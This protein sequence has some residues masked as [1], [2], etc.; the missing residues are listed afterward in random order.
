M[1]KSAFVL[2]FV[3]ILFLLAACG[4]SPEE[5]A[6]MTAAAATDTPTPTSTP[7]NTPTPT[8]TPTPTPIPYDLTVAVTD[9]EDGSPITTGQVSVAESGDGEPTPL[10]DAGNAVWLGLPG[11]TASISVTAQGYVGAEQST[12]LERGPNVVEI[13]LERDPRQVLPATACMEGETVAYIEDFEDGFAQGWDWANQG[14]PEGWLVEAGPNETLM[15][16]AAGGPHD[17]T[18]YLILDGNFRLDFDF[19]RVNGGAATAIGG[20]FT[21]YSN[22]HISATRI[23]SQLTVTANG[24]VVQTLEAPENVAAFEAGGFNEFWIDNVVLCQ[25]P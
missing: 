5:I 25:M 16:H 14:L 6:A 18:R 11:E 20:W 4:P 12:T 19:I 13:I 21:L 22:G 9:G 7:T 1:K 15:L 23:G 3:V 2:I 24:G 8:S 10:D 17:P